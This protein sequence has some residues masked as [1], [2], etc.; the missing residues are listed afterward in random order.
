MP[1]SFTPTIPYCCC[2]ETDRQNDLE[3]TKLVSVV[4]G[5]NPGHCAHSTREAP[6]PSHTLLSTKAKPSDWEGRV[7]EQTALCCGVEGTLPP[8]ASKAHAQPLSF[9]LLLATQVQFFIFLHVNVKIL[10]GQS[11]R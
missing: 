11:Q 9:C 8:A 3:W 5:S 10:V 7:R 4:W 1:L 6:V 2:F